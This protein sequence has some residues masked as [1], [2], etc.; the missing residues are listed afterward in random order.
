M[1][2]MLQMFQGSKSESYSQRLVDWW[3]F[4]IF[5]IMDFLI[6]V[7]FIITMCLRF[8]IEF[9]YEVKGAYVINL[10]FLFFKVLS[11][12]SASSNLGPKLVMIT[13]MVRT[14]QY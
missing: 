4:S 3:K 13:K 12:Y 8:G 14:L 10:I 2:V 5:H 1:F 6:M 11:Y 7:T 9:R